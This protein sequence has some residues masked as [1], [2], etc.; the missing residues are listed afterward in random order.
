MAD[1]HR[2]KNRQPYKV[3]QFL[4]HRERK[5]QQTWQEQLEVVKR[6]HTTFGGGRN[7]NGRTPSG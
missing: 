5:R 6:L 7:G 4:A 1:I 3:E 2:G